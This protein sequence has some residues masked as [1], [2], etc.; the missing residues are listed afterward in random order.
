MRESGIGQQ[1]A[2]RH[3]SYMMTMM[4]MVMVMVVMINVV[5]SFMKFRSW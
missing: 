1:A 4:V 3:D 5:L 2:Q